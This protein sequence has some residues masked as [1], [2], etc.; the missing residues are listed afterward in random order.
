VEAVRYTPTWVE[1]PSYRIRP[2]LQTLA[3][4]SASPAMRT[5]LR[6]SL[7]RTTT[8]IGRAARLATP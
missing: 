8:A 6:T 3:R 4:G 5:A 7:H 2:V 1:H